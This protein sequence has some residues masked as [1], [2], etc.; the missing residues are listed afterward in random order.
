[1]GE[2]LYLLARDDAEVLQSASV[3]GER[4]AADVEL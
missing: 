3:E 1:V 2:T 4:V